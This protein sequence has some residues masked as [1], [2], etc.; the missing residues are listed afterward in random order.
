MKQIRIFKNQETKYK[1]QRQMM[2]DELVQRLAD[3]LAT[4]LYSSIINATSKESQHCSSKQCVQNNRNLCISEDQPLHPM[5][6]CSFSL[7][8]AL[9]NI[10]R[11]RGLYGGTQSLNVFQPKFG[12]SSS[13]YLGLNFLPNMLFHSPMK[14]PTTLEFWSV[15]LHT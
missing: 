1:R 2:E 10:L 8:F 7:D 11:L 13:I 5:C 9:I 14:L 4:N 12:Y 6:K 3:K 15:Q